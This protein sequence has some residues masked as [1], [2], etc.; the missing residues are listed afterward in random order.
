MALI[1]DVKKE[2]RQN[3]TAS[4][5]EISDLIATAK[6]DLLL[7]GVL[8]TDETNPLIKRALATYC[9]ANFGFDNAVAERLAKA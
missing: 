3:G 5:T 4:D 1:D 6:A 8:T 7:S 2:L 9:K